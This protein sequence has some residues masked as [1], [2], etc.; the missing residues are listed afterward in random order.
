MVFCTK[1]DDVPMNLS[2]N[3][4]FQRHLVRRFRKDPSVLGGSFGVLLLYMMPRL[5]EAKLRVIGK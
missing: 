1:L 4:G 2:L 5:R 3:S